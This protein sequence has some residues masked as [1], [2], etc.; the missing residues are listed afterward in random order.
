MSTA[1]FLENYVRNNVCTYKSALFMPIV[2]GIMM[3]DIRQPAMVAATW[4]IV[5]FVWLVIWLVF[6]CNPNLNCTA[7]VNAQGKHGKDGTKALLVS[8]LIVYASLFAVAVAA[9]IFICEKSET[10][11]NLYNG[12]VLS[13]LGGFFNLFNK[14]VVIGKHAQGLTVP[15]ITT[16]EIN[17]AITDLRISQYKKSFEKPQTAFG[18]IANKY[19]PIK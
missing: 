19:S 5:I 16:N 6:P 15:K 17:R 9:R 10:P 7:T 11:T 8:F 18:S 14:K 13:N 1:T 4:G 3:V 2:P 12:G